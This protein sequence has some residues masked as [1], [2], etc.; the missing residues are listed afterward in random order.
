MRL[1]LSSFLQRLRRAALKG[2]VDIDAAPLY[3]E[4]QDL[5][6]L[7]WQRRISATNVGTPQLI[8]GGVAVLCAIANVAVGS[9]IPW[10]F[11]C[12]VSYFILLTFID[13]INFSVSNGAIASVRDLILDA[14]AEVRACLAEPARPWRC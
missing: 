5:Y 12:Y 8:F 7:V 3:I 2:D 9:C 13:L 1:A 11:I 14:R 4:L 6:A 10:F